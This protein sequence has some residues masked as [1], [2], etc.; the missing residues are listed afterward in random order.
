MSSSPAINLPA[1]FSCPKKNNCRSWIIGRLRE[2][3]TIIIIIY[4][5]RLQLSL[6]S[7]LSIFRTNSVPPPPVLTRKQSL[8]SISVP[9]H[10][11]LFVLLL[12][13]LV[14]HSHPS[15]TEHPYHPP[16]QPTKERLPSGSVHSRNDPNSHLPSEPTL[17]FSFLHTHKKALFYF[18]RQ[19]LT[20]LTHFPNRS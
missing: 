18:L 7:T 13:L 17:F 11:I 20:Y 6:F 9:P 15:S 2:L 4:I 19:S 3:I 1:D 10:S 14:L 5:F 16:S 8:H 12:Y